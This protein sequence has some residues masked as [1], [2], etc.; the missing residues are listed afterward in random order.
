MLSV[1]QEWTGLAQTVLSRPRLHALR[2][3]WSGQRPGKRK[4]HQASGAA[5]DFRPG[6]T[7]RAL[8][9]AL[10]VMMRGPRSPSP[11]CRHDIRG[12]AIASSIIFV[13]FFSFMC[14]IRR[15]T[16]TRQRQIRPVQIFFPPFG[17]KLCT[18]VSSE[19]YPGYGQGPGKKVDDVAETL[20]RSTH[21]GTI[22][23]G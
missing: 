11:R 13:N 8:V 22:A 9:F 1:E 19:R 12:I 16:S 23:W 2:A 6:P 20:E 4:D 21:R 3:V 17:Q 7:L 18:R 10:V 5:A 15:A 14:W